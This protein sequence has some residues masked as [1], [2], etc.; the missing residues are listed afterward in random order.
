MIQNIILTI[1]MLITLSGCYNIE[2][3]NHTQIN[4][5]EENSN[6]QQVITRLEGHA[7]TPEEYFELAEAYMQRSGLKLSDMI[8]NISD[9]TKDAKSPFLAFVGSVKT[10]TATQAQSIED[11]NK[12]TDYHML[13]IGD[14]CKEGATLTNFEKDVCLYKGLAQTME[15]AN[16]INSMSDDVSKI[17]TQGDAKLQASSCAMQ[18]AFN[19][20]IEKHCSI[21]E[22]GEVTF[23]ESTTTYD[24]IAV[25]SNGKEFEYLLLKDEKTHTR[26]LVVTQGYCNVDNFNSRESFLTNTKSYP[27][28]V[29]TQEGEDEITTNDNLIDSLN[30]GTD[31]IL[32]VADNYKELAQSVREFKI[33]I[34]A[35]RKDEQQQQNQTQDPIIIK[36]EIDMQDMIE[37]LNN[38]NTLAR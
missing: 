36:V 33:E 21:S 12:A 19:G 35:T 14:R 34:T 4:Q 2:N 27:C 28:P 9:T 6:Y 5:Q 24:R 25:Y 18:Y 3:S 23:N 22:I 29:T 15:V 32:A 8:Q 11:L 20:I 13:I 7:S 26:E 31:A 1:M 10:S 30:E 16:T 38:Q 17:D 37:Y